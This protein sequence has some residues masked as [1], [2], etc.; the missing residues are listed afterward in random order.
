MGARFLFAIWCNPRVIKG[1]RYSKWFPEISRWY[2]GSLGRGPD[3]DR[4]HLKC[5]ISFLVNQ[6][7][8]RS[9]IA[10]YNSISVL[11]FYY[12]FQLRY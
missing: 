8:L 6:K 4:G 1:T 3:R 9:F 11:A 10:I 7:L 12:I 2:Q 5:R